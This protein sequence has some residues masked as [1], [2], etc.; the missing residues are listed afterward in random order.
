MEMGRLLPAPKS[1]GFSVEYASVV[2]YGRASLVDE[3]AERMYGMQ[4]L[5]EK[6]A[7][8]LQPGVDY[9]A[10]LP[11]ELEGTAVYRLEIEAWS[12]KRKQ[13]AADH[14]GAYDYQ[15]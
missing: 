1:R 9:R 14:P 7:P 8:H 6:Y 3:E 4:L 11:E 13:A 5:M 10:L 12:G 2:V 15:V